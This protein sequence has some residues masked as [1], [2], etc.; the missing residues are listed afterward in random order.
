MLAIQAEI[1]D[2]TRL[3][4]QAEDYYKYSQMLER[5]GYI[6]RGPARSGQSRAG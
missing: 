1:Q 2:K 3:L 5:K 4:S 6:T